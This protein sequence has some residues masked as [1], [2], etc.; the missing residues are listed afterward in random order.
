MH[1]ARTLVL[2]S[3]WLALVPLI[4]CEL[5]A[6]FDRS[7]IPVSDAGSADAGRATDA[8]V[9]KDAAAN[10]DAGDEDAGEFVETPA[11]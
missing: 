2:C 7:K 8:A 3:L 6:D 4:G 9:S 10:D 11:P 1:N 5:I